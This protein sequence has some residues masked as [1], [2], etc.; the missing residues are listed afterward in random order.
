MLNKISEAKKTG[1]KYNLKIED[2]CD[3]MSKEFSD[4]EK[5]DGL[6]ALS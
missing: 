5:A 3:I 6:Y 4:L 1:G 2:C